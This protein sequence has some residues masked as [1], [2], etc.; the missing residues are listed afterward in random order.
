MRIHKKNN[1][2]MRNL[3]ASDW[4]E[5][6]SGKTGRLLSAPQFI[7]LRPFVPF[8]PRGRFP[9]LFQKMDFNSVKS[10]LFIQ[11]LA[12]LILAHS[13]ESV[14][15]IGGAHSA[16]N[17]VHILAAMTPCPHGLIN[18][19]L[20]IKAAPR[21]VLIAHEVDVPVFAFMSWPARASA[22]PAY[23]AAIAAQVRAA[24]NPCG[25]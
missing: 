6:F 5:I 19:L 14:R 17:L 12:A 8:V 2:A 9:F 11:M 7:M 16:L 21:A 13:A 4:Q 25:F 23:G 3:S 18:N 20:F 15:Q 22:Y 10:A 1:N 24:F